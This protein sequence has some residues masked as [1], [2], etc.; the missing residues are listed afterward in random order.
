MRG[1]TPKRGR[2]GGRRRADISSNSDTKHINVYMN[3]CHEDPSMYSGKCHNAIVH[4]KTLQ[5][6]N[7]IRFKGLLNV[8]TLHTKNTHK[9]REH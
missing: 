7:H 2:Q 3:T 5:T 9:A 6:C 1:S 8:T 4:H